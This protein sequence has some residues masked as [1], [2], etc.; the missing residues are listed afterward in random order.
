MEKICKNCKISKDINSFCIANNNKDGYQDCKKFYLKHREEILKYHK[1]SYGL[2]FEE[3][4]QMLESQNG[5][6]AICGDK[7]TRKHNGKIV[8]LSIDHNHKT[9]QIRGLL[10][11]NGNSILLSSEDDEQ[12]E[13]IDDEACFVKIEILF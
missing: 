13:P 11:Q 9:G 8:D 7:E 6:C 1:N 4:N 2:T 10:C 5:V 12:L 3:Y